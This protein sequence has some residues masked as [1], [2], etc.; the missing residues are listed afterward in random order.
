MQRK[1]FFAHAVSVC[2][3]NALVHI[4][5]RLGPVGLGSNP[6][7]TRRMQ[8]GRMGKNDLIVHDPESGGTLRLKETIYADSASSLAEKLRVR[9]KKKTGDKSPALGE[10]SRLAAAFTNVIEKRAGYNRKHCS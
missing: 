5:A 1:T 4:S 8:Y 9:T 6:T 10:R 7:A 3:L 2:W